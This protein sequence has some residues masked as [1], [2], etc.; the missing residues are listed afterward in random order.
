MSDTYHGWANI[1]TWRVQ[2]HLHSNEDLHVWCA[3]RA[4]IAARGHF[5]PVDELAGHIRDL[6]ETEVAE[7][8]ETDNDGVDMFVADTMESV[9]AQVDWQ[10]I[11]RAWLEP[12]GVPPFGGGAE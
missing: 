11:A 12:A 2:L 9:L 5:D 10:E 7:I 3:G 6:V 8:V 4:A 1:H